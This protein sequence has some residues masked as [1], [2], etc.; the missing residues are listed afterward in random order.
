MHFWT[1]PIF[2][3]GNKPRPFDPGPILSW[4]TG[5]LLIGSEDRQPTY[6]QSVG[7]RLGLLRACQTLLRGV[8]SYYSQQISLVGSC[9]APSAADLDKSGDCSINK[10]QEQ[11]LT[12][13]QNDLTKARKTQSRLDDA[14]LIRW[15]SGLA[16]VTRSSVKKIFDRAV[17]RVRN[18]LNKCRQSI[19]MK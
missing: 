19:T 16:R 18:L 9:L 5:P 8:E 4:H 6:H 7:A 1:L 10:P 3:I 12:V 17:P 13:L 14:A 2:S 15:R 11:G